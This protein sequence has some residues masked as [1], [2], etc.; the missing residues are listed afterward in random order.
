MVDHALVMNHVQPNVLGHRQERHR[1]HDILVRS[2]ADPQQLP[3]DREVVGIGEPILAYGAVHHVGDGR[4]IEVPWPCGC[5]ESLHGDPTRLLATW[6]RHVER[7]CGID[8]DHLE[9]HYLAELRGHIPAA[10][11][12]CRAEFTAPAEDSM[13]S[14]RALEAWEAHVREEAISSRP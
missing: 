9:L 8:A 5:G 6:A 2:G 7:L 4:F 1:L 14:N 3:P 13:N 10:V 12:G 11:C